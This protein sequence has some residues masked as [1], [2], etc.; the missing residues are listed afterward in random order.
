MA[1]DRKYKSR[2]IPIFGE[3]NFIFMRPLF[4]SFLTLILVFSACRKKE[5]IEFTLNSLTLKVFQK[6]NYPAQ[7]VFLKVVLKGTS[8]DEVLAITDR[9]PAEYTLPAKFGLE[10]A[11]RLNFYKN[12]YAIELW[13]D[14]SGYISSNPIHLKDYRI[15]Y[16]LEMETENSGTS[17]VL[18]GTWK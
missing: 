13:G 17:I 1:E 8:A 2:L 7:K 18:S 4:I 14:S 6:E 9:Y 12:D 3:L 5:R 10:Q 15:I 16:P 11:P